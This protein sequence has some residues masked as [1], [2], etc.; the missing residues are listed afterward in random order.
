MARSIYSNENQV[1][2]KSIINIKHFTLLFIIVLQNILDKMF[3][4]SSNI[5]KLI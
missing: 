2:S 5:E 4:I 3:K 1:N